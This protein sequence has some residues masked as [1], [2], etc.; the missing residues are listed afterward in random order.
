MYPIDTRCSCYTC[1]NFTRAYLHHLFR[2]GEILAAT[3]A[4]IHNI[5]WFHQ[6]TDAMRQSIIEGEF[7]AFREKIH[8]AYPE[9]SPPVKKKGSGKQKKRSSKRN[10]R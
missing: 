4:S 5:A 8:Q 1:Q 10:R 9:R 6:F 3:L 2:V 7:S